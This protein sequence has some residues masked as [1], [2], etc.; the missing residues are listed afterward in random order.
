MPTPKHYRNKFLKEHPNAQ[1]REVKPLWRCCRE[2]RVGFSNKVG[3]ISEGWNTD[4]SEKEIY[5]CIQVA[6]DYNYSQMQKV[7]MCNDER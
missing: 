6:K 2:I 7:V 5:L 3:E 1:L 4:T